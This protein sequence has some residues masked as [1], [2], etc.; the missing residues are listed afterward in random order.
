MSLLISWLTF[1]SLYQN[2]MSSDCSPGPSK[3]FQ[4]SAQFYDGY[5][6]EIWREAAENASS[7][8]AKKRKILSMETKRQLHEL[9]TV[10]FA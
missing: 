1:H 3:Q 2:Q 6:A 8:L 9:I 7:D 10:T 5:R 4:N